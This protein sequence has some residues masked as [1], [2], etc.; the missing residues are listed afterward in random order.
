MGE[1]KFTHKKECPYC[2]T[3]N[4][5][6]FE[7]KGPVHHGDRQLGD[8][9][10]PELKYRYI[11]H[12]EKCINREFHASCAPELEEIIENDD[13][14]KQIIQ[15]K[16]CPFCGKQLAGD[17]FSGGTD[18]KDGYYAYEC[19]NKFCEYKTLKIPAYL[20]NKYR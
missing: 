19:G 11:C 14:V 18:T 10:V 12:S 5:D 4:L 2:Q 17:R 6:Y 1:I 15:E 7:F 8:P 3:T 13:M 9:V 16:K 20:Y